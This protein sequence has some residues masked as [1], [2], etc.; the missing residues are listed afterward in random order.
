MTFREKIFLN[1]CDKWY[2]L[3]KSGTLII[4]ECGTTLLPPDVLC[5]NVGGT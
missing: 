3:R 5:S 4:T 1:E 2:T